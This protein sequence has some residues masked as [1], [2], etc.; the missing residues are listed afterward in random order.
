MIMIATVTTEQADNGS[1]GL[2]APALLQEEVHLA[3]FRAAHLAG[4]EAA[5]DQQQDAV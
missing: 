5:Y 3:G 2:V 4:R 1:P